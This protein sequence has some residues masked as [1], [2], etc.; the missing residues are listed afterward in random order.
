M[1]RILSLMS[2]LGVA[3]LPT[4]AIAEG[5]TPNQGGTMNADP[6]YEA[7]YYRYYESVPQTTLSYVEPTAGDV[8]IRLNNRT[9]SNIRYQA[10]GDTDLRILEPG[11]S[12][13]LSDVE[14]PISVFVYREDNGLIQATANSSQAGMLDVDLGETQD[15]AA[16]DL[17]IRI[18]PEGAVYVR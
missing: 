12:T 15:F 7:N 1:K 3:A 6:N 14:V 16:A 13:M 10:V 4:A 11:S 2:L 17:S 5:M 8:R 18:S 9:N